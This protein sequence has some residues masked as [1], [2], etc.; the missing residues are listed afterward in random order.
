[1]SLDWLYLGEEMLI[2]IQREASV[3]ELDIVKKLLTLRL[4]LG[5]LSQQICSGTNPP[6]KSYS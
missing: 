3:L 2:H 5:K 4:V 1:M 6:S